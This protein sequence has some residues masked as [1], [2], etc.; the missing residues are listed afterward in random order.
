[1]LQLSVPLLAAAGGTALLGEEPSLRLVLGGA[2]IL[3]GVSLAVLRRQPIQGAE[4]H[5]APTAPRM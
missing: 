4:I 2:A 3:A 1:V 5:V